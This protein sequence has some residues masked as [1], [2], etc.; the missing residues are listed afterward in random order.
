MDSYLKY[1]I[2][3]IASLVTVLHEENI[4]VLGL[5]IV[6]E[7]DNVIVLHLRVDVALL[8]SVLLG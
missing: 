6:I 1:L 2:R 4:L 5:S 3:E 7:L 8:L